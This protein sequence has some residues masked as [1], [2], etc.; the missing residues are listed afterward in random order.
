MSAGFVHD[1]KNATAMPISAG[2]ARPLRARIDE[3]AV[4]RAIDTAIG[5]ARKRLHDEARRALG[6]ASAALRVD[7]TPDRGYLRFRVLC[8]AAYVAYVRGRMAHAERAIGYALLQAALLPED[9]RAS[10]RDL[11]RSNLAK[12]YDATGRAD[13]AFALRE[14][15]VRE[16]PSAVNVLN[17]AFACAGRARWDR[18]LHLVDVPVRFDPLERANVE[19]LR[20]LASTRL[21][22]GAA[23]KRAL[24][25][26]R[27]IL[28]TEGLPSVA[29]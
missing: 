22:R 23:A 26:Y 4:V 9:L 25:R 3:A 2:I 7:R 17:L 29:L 16:A 21:G 20:A 1:G 15:A 11:A 24:V 13:E 28:R 6:D 27:Q 10:A 12:I 5:F 8:C 18:V 19:L 14:R